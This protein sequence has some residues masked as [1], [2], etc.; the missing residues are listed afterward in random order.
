MA[1]ETDLEL[2]QLEQFYREMFTIRHFE[3]VVFAIYETGELPGATHLYNGQEAVSVGIAA[4]LRRD[5]YVAA[6]YRGH[7]VLLARGLAPRILF[8]E[9]LGKATGA[10]RGRAGSMNIVD[11]EHGTIGC[12]GIVGGSIPAATGAALA[13]QLHGQDRVAVAFFGDGAANQ[14]YFHESLNW[15]AVRKLPAVYVCENNLYGEWTAMDRVTSVTRLA[16]RAQAY[17]IPGVRV[18]GNDML[19]VRDAA[20]AAVDRA[21]GGE[22]PTLLECLT[23]RHRGHARSEPGLYRPRE[24]V[25]EWLTRDPLRR[26]DDRLPSDTRAAIERQVEAAIADALEAAR[27]DPLPDP[28]APQFATK[29]LV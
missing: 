25:A 8:A 17:A 19:A 16:D 29:E 13:A 20:R 21:R 2:E 7:G 3:D 23:Y 15:A 6:T 22:G 14:A 9:M 4:A 27:A 28:T 5:D 1:V 24:E 26:L 10:C 11:L 18:D 12:F